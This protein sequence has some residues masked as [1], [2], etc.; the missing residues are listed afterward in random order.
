LSGWVES[1]APR[2]KGVAGVADVIRHKRDRK[3]LHDHVDVW[4]TCIKSTI[5]DAPAKRG[6]RKGLGE[7]DE[8]RSG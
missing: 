3:G 2:Q 8:E 4:G 7:T 5:E 1:C 6:G